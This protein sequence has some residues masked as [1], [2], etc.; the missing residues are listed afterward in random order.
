MEDYVGPRHQAI[1]C[2]TIADVAAY[3]ETVLAERGEFATLSQVLERRLREA[4][5]VQERRRLALRLGDLLIGPL[6]R[7]RDAITLLEPLARP[8]RADPLEA[9]YEQALEAG[10][11]ALPF[12]L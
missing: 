3:L 2:A 7:P 9:L 8:G 10:A 12:H 1:Q 6:G 5:E 11:E 4:D